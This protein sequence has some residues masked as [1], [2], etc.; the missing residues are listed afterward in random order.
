MKLN[1]INVLDIYVYGY[2]LIIIH[3]VCMININFYILI[4]TNNQ[5]LTAK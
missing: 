3:T 2:T 4:Q 1:Y 5:T